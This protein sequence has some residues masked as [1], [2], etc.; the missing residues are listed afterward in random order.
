MSSCDLQGNREKQPRARSKEASPWL[1]RRTDGVPGEHSSARGPGDAQGRSLLDAGTEPP[2][3][4]GREAGMSAVESPPGSS[5]HDAALP[6]A[7]PLCSQTREDRTRSQAF[8]PDPGFRHIQ[9]DR[10]GRAHALTSKTRLTDFADPHGRPRHPADTPRT[11]G[12]SPHLLR[13]VQRV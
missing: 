4:G 11:A 13:G 8:T 1:K 3:T 10:S 2:G 5:A 9:V 6:T 7:V 12:R